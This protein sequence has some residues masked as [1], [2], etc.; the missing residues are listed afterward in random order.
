M[1]AAS[2]TH[3]VIVNFFKSAT[4]ETLYA[5]QLYLSVAVA[6]VVAV[7]SFR[8]YRQTKFSG[9]LFWIYG[10]LLTLGTIIAWDIIGH[11]PQAYPRLYSAAVIGYRA[12]FVVNTLLSFAGTVLVIREFVRLSKG[13]RN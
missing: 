7:L 4:S 9:F 12:M 5:I 6:L 8:A 11:S 3:Q 13:A 1:G 10:S 2:A